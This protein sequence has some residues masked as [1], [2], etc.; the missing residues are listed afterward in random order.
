MLTRSLD[1]IIRATNC[2]PDHLAVARRHYGHSP[3]T[4]Q[5]FARLREALTEVDIALL[6]RHAAAPVLPPEE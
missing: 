3:R 2:L 4:V 1:E 5:A 6:G